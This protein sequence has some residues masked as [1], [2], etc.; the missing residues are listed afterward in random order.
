[1][2]SLSRSVDCCLV[3]YESATY[4]AFKTRL[5]WRSLGK[6]FDHVCSP[7]SCCVNSLLGAPRLRALRP[8]VAP[9]S[10]TGFDTYNACSRPHKALHHFGKSAHQLYRYSGLWNGPGL[11]QYLSD[12]DRCSQSA[13][14]AI[15]E[16]VKILPFTVE[17]VHLLTTDF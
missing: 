12:A 1:M 3:K 9:T 11:S 6:L 17:F 5:Q 8:H 15:R 7:G 10:T 4:N 13:I 14:Y 16:K 2:A